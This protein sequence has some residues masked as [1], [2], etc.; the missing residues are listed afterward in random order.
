MASMNDQSKDDEPYGALY[1][2]GAAS[3]AVLIF[4]VAIG[5]WM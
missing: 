1:E 2:F 5:W 4:Y 3:I